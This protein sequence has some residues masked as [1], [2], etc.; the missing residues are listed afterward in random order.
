MSVPV[1]PQSRHNLP[2]LPWVELFVSDGGPWVNPQGC[3]YKLSFVWKWN[4]SYYCQCCSPFP[5]V[6]PGCD[7][8]PSFTQ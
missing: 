1:I 5:S 4:I 3:Q 2:G 7:A 8:K 6:F